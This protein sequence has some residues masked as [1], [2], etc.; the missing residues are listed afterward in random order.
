MVHPK[1][2]ADRRRD[3]IV[4]DLHSRKYHPRVIARKTDE[5]TDW[6]EDLQDY[7]DRTRSR[8]TDGVSSEHVD[9]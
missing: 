8:S 6:E 2:R 4:K 1:N 9:D 7:Y 5:D 3:R